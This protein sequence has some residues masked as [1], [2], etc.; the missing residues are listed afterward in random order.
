M[1]VLDWVIAITLVVMAYRGY[2]RG[3][4]GQIFEL[5][6]SIMAIVGAFY[7]FERVGNALRPWLRVSENLANVAG[8]ILTA[9]VIALAFGYIGRQWN[10][11]VKSSSL[12][13]VDGLAGSAFGVFKILVIMIF[14]LL[15]MVNIPWE[16][17]RKPIRES[18]LAQDILR[19]TPFFYLLQERSLPANV[20]RLMMTP[21][22]LQLRKFNYQELDGAT[23]ISCG[24]K[25][26]YDGIKSQGV[27]SYP[28]FTCPQCGRVSDGCQT[29]EGYHKMYGR[30]PSTESPNNCKVWPNPTGVV[31]KGLC[32][33]CTKAL[34][35]EI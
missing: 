7:L 29:Y 13:F 11:M 20:P 34:R 22:G 4:V 16:V 28:H 14:I 24:G 25:V 33:V 19:L 15:L 35:D 6:G 31:P 23:C 10:K 26:H 3:F 18:F 30:C 1:T 8:F 9:V 5:L 21:E 32:P 27:M 2:R 17:T 12:T